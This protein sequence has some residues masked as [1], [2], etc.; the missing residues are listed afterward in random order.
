MT[1]GLENSSR[2][3]TADAIA[4]LIK[5]KQQQGWLVVYLGANQDAW[6]VAN[7]LGIRDTST[8]SFSVASFNEVACSLS[9]IT[10]HYVAAGTEAHF[11]AEDRKRMG[12]KTD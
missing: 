9:N 7:T 12:G 1:D 3:F 8:A 6:T 5:A 11:S 4:A 10:S 2:E